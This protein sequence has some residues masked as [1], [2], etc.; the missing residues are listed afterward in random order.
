MKQ[1]ADHQV[2]V[3]SQVLAHTSNVGYEH[4]HNN[5]VVS[6]NGVRITSLRQMVA[7]IEGNAERWL[8]FDLDPYEERVV[9]DASSL[10]AVNAELLHS[11]QIPADRSSDLQRG[12]AAGGSSQGHANGA[13]EPREKRKRAR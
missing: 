6:L 11:H 10:P 9:L 5:I 1:A 13:S 7:L 8:A 4:L 12:A 2:V 3:L